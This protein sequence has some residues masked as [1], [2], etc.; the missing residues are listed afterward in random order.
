MSFSVLYTPAFEKEIKKLSKKYPS[1][2]KD[3][4]L[5]VESLKANPIQG[6][7]LGNHCYKIRLGILSKNTGK[8]GGVRI[9][10]YVRIINEEVILISIYDK[11]GR[12]NISDAE[13]KSRLK[14]YFE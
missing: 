5:L 1:L 7:S 4:S 11:P 13:I 9:I 12:A 2:T 8:S 10:T 6:I 14:K 3:F